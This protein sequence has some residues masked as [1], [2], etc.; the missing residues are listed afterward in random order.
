MN[1]DDIEDADNDEIN[2]DEEDDDEPG[3]ECPLCGRTDTHNH[4][5]C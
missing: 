4:D 5:W 1:P 2:V 3:D